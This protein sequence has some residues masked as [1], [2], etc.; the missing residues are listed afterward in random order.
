MPSYYDESSKSRYCKFYYTDYTGAK[1]QK[2]K[3]GFKLQREAKKQERNFP[4]TQQAAPIMNFKNSATI[5]NEDM[6]K[7]LSFYEKL[8]E[9]SSYKN[10]SYSEEWKL[11]N[12][13]EN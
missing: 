12:H 5:Y 10:M 7:K 11:F 6:K 8:L 1:K 9:D 13:G 2:K 3:R 4:K